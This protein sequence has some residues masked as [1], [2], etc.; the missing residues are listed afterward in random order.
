MGADVADGRS[1]CDRRGHPYTYVVAEFPD[2]SQFASLV[3]VLDDAAGRWPA[4][5]PMW[6][7]RASEM[8]SHSDPVLVL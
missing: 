3:D 1:G 8:R 5:P 7:P 6:N 2:I 4:M